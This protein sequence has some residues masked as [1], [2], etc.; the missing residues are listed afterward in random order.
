MKSFKFA[1]PIV[2]MTALSMIL[3]ACGGSNGSSGSEGKETGGNAGDSNKPVKITFLNSKGQ[4]QAAAEEA[5]KK[6]TAANPNIQVEVLTVASGQSPFERASVLYASGNPAT[7]NMLD[8][9][10]IV[11]F[12]DKALDLSGEQWVKDLAQPNQLDGKTLAFPFAVE[13]YG[14]VYNKKVL[15]KAVG[16]TFDP[17]T[18]HTTSA[19]EAL[20]KKVEA[21]GTAPLIIGAM[22]WSLGNHF[23]PIAY[24]SQPKGDVSAFIGG[25]RTGQEKL[26]GNASFNGL[27]DTLEMMKKYNKRKNDPLVVTA[28]DIA[29][30]VAKGEAAITFNGNWMISQL[31]SVQPNGEYGFMP[32]PTSN[33][34]DDKKNASIPVGATK[35]IFIDKTV[36]TAA[37]QEA[38]KKFLNW[39]VYDAAGQDFLVNKASILPA[40]KN[41]TLEPADSLAKSIK[42]YMNADKTL[43]FGANYVPGDHSKMIGAAMQKYL[44]GE[45]D[46]A[47]LAAEIEGYWK[48]VK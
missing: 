18:I 27:I 20:F 33:N 2:L 8:A 48:N 23:L 41:I 39:I 35:Q 7:L 10:D 31:D 47:G 16:G 34:A 4:I 1:K 19:L 9:G 46:R 38:A 14:L 24:A 22:P 5:A 28:E 15:D 40:F 44:G 25:L 32:V 11:K 21:S 37:Q 17:S 45:S 3:A 30:A 29:G 42:T 13:G 36:A 43:Q 26:A 6:F 12:K